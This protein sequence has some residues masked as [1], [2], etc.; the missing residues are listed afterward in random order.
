MTRL[1][2]L[3]FFGAPRSHD[4]EH[5]H[6]SSPVMTVP[7]AILATLAVVAAGLELPLPGDLGHI[8]KRFM[9]PVFDAG[10]QNLLAAHHFHAVRDA[11]TGALT[12][13]AHPVWPY[14]AA[15]LI[16]AVGT[17]VAWTMYMGPLKWLPAKLMIGSPNLY[18][19]A[20]EKFRVD[21]LYDFLIIRPL[22]RLAWLLWKVVDVILIDSGLVMGTARAFG[23]I[24]KVLRGFQN[25]D[26]QRYAALM[27][28][29]AAIILFTVLGAGG[30]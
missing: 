18:K 23:A 30:L 6:E 4:A 7:L 28:L 13:A 2:F 17:Y 14:F 21:E 3:V 22:K 19:F 9:E 1:I 25:G 27:A 15:W 26:M 24:G 5:A 11:F 20:Y 10:T 12:E 8:Y 29:A 16:A